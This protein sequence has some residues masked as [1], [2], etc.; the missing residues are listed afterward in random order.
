MRCEEVQSQG[1]ARAEDCVLAFG[2]VSPGTSDVALVRIE[3]PSAV[4]GNVSG[5]AL[6]GSDA[7]SL[8]LLVNDVER[9]IDVVTASDPVTAFPLEAEAEDPTLSNVVE[10]TFAPLALGRQDARLLIESDAGNAEGTS[11]AQ[12]G[13]ITL[14]LIGE[15]VE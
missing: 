10:I 14:S 7:F 13:T 2:P 15:T 12:Y 5:I 1:C 8:R 4:N 6:D 9:P 11:R 3:N